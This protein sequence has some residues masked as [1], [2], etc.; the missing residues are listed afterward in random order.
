MSLHDASTPEKVQG[1]NKVDHKEKRRSQDPPDHD[2][3]TGEEEKLPI[4]DH[5][6][7]SPTKPHDIEE[8]AEA[9]EPQTDKPTFGFNPHP[10]P[11][12]TSPADEEN[13]TTNTDADTTDNPLPSSTS[14]NSFK[15]HTSP[16]F[17]TTTS[18]APSHLPQLGI[19]DPVPPQN[20]TSPTAPANAT[21]SGGEFN[22]SGKW[23]NNPFVSPLFWG[24]GAFYL[25][26]AYWEGWQQARGD[27]VYPE[28][29]DAGVRW[30]GE[31][32]VRHF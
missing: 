26:F 29:V 5:E 27:V 9:E 6:A 21:Q 18:S 15:P 24:V 7:S 30:V 32:M 17:P 16:S 10:R 14:Y 8:G 22:G 20:H 13:P 19:T 12:P 1:W 2:H 28:F 11:L 25:A 23:P 3:V 4:L 31:G